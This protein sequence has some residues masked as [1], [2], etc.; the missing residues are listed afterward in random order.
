MIRIGNGF[1]VHPFEEGKP[2]FLGGIKI[3]HTHGMQGHSD[4]DVLLHAA[5]DALLGASALGD[6]GTYFK[7][8]D[9]SLNNIASTILLNRVMDLVR[10]KNYRV[11]NFDSTI[12]AQQPRLAPHVQ[13][14]RQHLAEC[15]NVH[16]DCV[17]V[18]ATTTD[19]LGFV[20]RSEGIAAIANVLIEQDQP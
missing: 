11:V 10:E 13:A 19:H 5:C 4:G 15:F 20:G 3:P 6:L 9:A 2:L 12:I 8:N 18:K 1:D 14:M 17:S 16:F 7:D